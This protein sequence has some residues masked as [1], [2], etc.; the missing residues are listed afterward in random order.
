M[1][2]Q[3]ILV[4]IDFSD[5]SHQALEVA[6][7]MAAHLGATLLLVHIVSAIPDLPE[8]VS[9]LKQGEYENQLH[10]AAA[11]RLSDL[12]STLRDRNI[13]ART[14]VGTANDVAMELVR[15]AEHDAVDL[16]IIS[17]H[18]MTGWRPIAFGSVA[19]VVVEQAN[20]PV[21]LLRVKAVANIV[22]PETRGLAAH[23]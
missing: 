14:E 7:G 19:K 23:S 17:T 15:I 2:P 11:K 20:C 1:P 9:M 5:H 12:A 21:L 10:D 4:P 22:D 16:I 3:L 6:T 18:G 8:G 13:T